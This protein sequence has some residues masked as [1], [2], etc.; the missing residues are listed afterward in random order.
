M[1]CE[2]D[3]SDMLKDICTLV[4]RVLFIDLLPLLLAAIVWQRCAPLLLVIF[5]FMSF[6]GGS[7]HRST[8]CFL[9]MKCVYRS[10]V[11]SGR[12]AEGC[13]KLNCAAATAINSR[14]RA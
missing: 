3:E 10:V 1:A 12:Q 6:S 5:A 11:L 14:K 9:I 7:A 4:A 8:S 13:A 2:N